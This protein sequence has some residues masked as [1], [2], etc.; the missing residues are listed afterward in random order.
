M[1]VKTDINKI[2]QYLEEM[3]RYLI[4][5]N[6][7]IN[8]NTQKNHIRILSILIYSFRNLIL[9]IAINYLFC[10]ESTVLFSDL[11]LKINNFQY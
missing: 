10:V 4:F 1:G 9:K 2:N 3:E 8:V 6:L 5:F 7:T 11:I